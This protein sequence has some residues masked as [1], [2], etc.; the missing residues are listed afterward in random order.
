MTEGCSPKACLESDTAAPEP[1]NA[2]TSCKRI[3]APGRHVKV[4]DLADAQ[5]QDHTAG[6]P[7][8]IF[9]QGNQVLQLSG[10]VPAPGAQ[11]GPVQAMPIC[12]QQPQPWQP[13]A[14]QQMP[15]QTF[16][17]I[18]AAAAAAG[19]MAAIRQ[20]PA[21][22]ALAHN[23]TPEQNA[24]FMAAANAAASAAAAQA[25]ALTPT[26]NAMS[27]PPAIAL[28]SRQLQFVSQAPAMSEAMPNHQ[29]TT[30]APMAQ[31]PARA[32]AN[33]AAL[34]PAASDTSAHQ[35]HQGH[36]EVQLQADA[37]GRPTTP[38]SEASPFEQALIKR[39]Q[40]YAWL[41]GDQ[42]RQV[43]QQSL[44]ETAARYAER[45]THSSMAPADQCSPSAARSHGQGG[46]DDNAATSLPPHG[47]MTSNH[48]K[49]P[50]SGP[51]SADAAARSG[52]D[53]AARPSAG[54]SSPYTGEA[55]RAALSGDRHSGEHGE[56]GYNQAPGP[57]SFAQDQ[58][59][60]PQASLSA[61][62]GGCTAAGSQGD[63]AEEDMEGA[64]RPGADAGDAAMTGPPGAGGCAAA[65]YPADPVGLRDYLLRAGTSMMD[66]SMADQSDGETA[67]LLESRPSL[68]DMWP[69]EDISPA[70]AAN[71]D[72][73]Q[74]RQVQG[75]G[76]GNDDGRDASYGDAGDQPL[77]T[78][79]RT[80]LRDL[81]AV[82][83]ST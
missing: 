70:P 29:A 45:Q 56:S 62:Q 75:V 40:L 43:L 30:T 59:Y 71:D 4:D 16:T 81:H 51:G 52:P 7:T 47:N 46:G 57:R 74:K 78:G 53:A 50:W 38:T 63:G 55:Q 68:E 8:P 9:V 14:A 12:A 48:H 64:S 25:V 66:L 23:G 31:Q 72:E 67:G 61:A 34:R 49:R 2:D 15:L 10:R 6:A 26:S 69:V 19:A 36:H 79:P 1:T 22:Q 18:I 44:R 37:P 20:L 17:S 5:H 76:S 80:G 24:A 13:Q 54:P 35:P 27:Q 42:G 11:A 65:V 32:D 82:S 21:A 60:S 3:S 33:A 41:V 39:L 77:L 28:P 58:G 83:A 73:R